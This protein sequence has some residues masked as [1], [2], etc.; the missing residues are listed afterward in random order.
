MIRRSSLK[1][2]IL[3]ALV[4]AAD[5][6]GAVGETV[7]VKNRYR[8]IYGMLGA[9]ASSPK[10]ER[11]D[12][13]LVELSAEGLIKKQGSEL[14][15]LT[16]AGQKLK[17]RLLYE[18][19]RDWD[20]K[21]RMVFFDIP[22][23]RRLKRDALRRELMA[24]GFGSWQRS[25]WITPFDVA[26][27]LRVYIEGKKL[28]RNVDIFVGKRVGEVGDR[29]FAASIWPVETVNKR[30]ES[31]LRDWGKELQRESSSE[32]RQQVIVR[33]QDRFLRIFSDDP[34]L[35]RALLPTDWKGEEAKELYSKLVSIVA[36]T[37]A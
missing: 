1:D 19:K 22:E 11:I 32:Q 21:W 20:G 35:P 18:Q 7:P 25:C 14:P 33:L 31:L 16:T 6:L 3:T 29:E 12:T 5:V 23:K 28:T 26:S 13:L 9:T 4:L 10:R 34:H 2:Q 17:R 27:E 37:T 15:Y 36:A 24:L 30:Y 8:M